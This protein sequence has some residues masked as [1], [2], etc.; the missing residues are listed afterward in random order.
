MD[1][2]YIEAVQRVLAPPPTS[3]SRKDLD[4]EAHFPRR[5]AL[6]EALSPWLNP[7]ERVVTRNI[8]PV[9]THTHTASETFDTPSSA[10]RIVVHIAG[11]NGKGSVCELLRCSSLAAGHV[12]GTFT[13][14]HLHTIRERMRVGSELI[15]KEDFARIAN[16][17]LPIFEA[18]QWMVFFDKL[19][20]VALVWFGEKRINFLVLETG[21]GGRFDPTNFVNNPKLCVLTGIGLDHEDMLGSTVAAIAWQKAGIIK[22]GCGALVTHCNQH[23]DALAVILEAAAAAGVPVN[24]AG[25]YESNS[26]KGL[27]QPVPEDDSD[28]VSSSTTVACCEE[29]CRSACVPS[30]AIQENLDIARA[31]VKVLGLPEDWKNSMWP[32]RFEEFWAPVGDRRTRVVVDGAH[33]VCGLQ[34]LKDRLAARYPLASVILVFGAAVDK[35][36]SGMVTLACKIAVN[37]IFVAARGPRATPPRALA[38]HLLADWGRAPGTDVTYRP[39]LGPVSEEPENGR[40]E[41]ESSAERSTE[42]SAESSCVEPKK[43][44]EESETVSVSRGLD[45]A[46]KLA[47]LQQEES[48]VVVC[49]SLFVAAEAREALA[50][51]W[52]FLFSDED[53]VHCAQDDRGA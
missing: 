23:A 44:L 40:T 13:S 49:G 28:S 31:C 19:L 3:L 24:L 16:S 45:A 22:K 12:V 33:N 46:V 47:S 27:L 25:D 29:S 32:A 35:D 34:S 48:M 37:I 11:T 15:T 30:W 17:L 7:K 6:F 50:A 41:E 20:A 18:N 51:R 26:D 4:A 52:S 9:H 39:L 14:P 43:V 36:T 1:I 8:D 21:I 2:T 5:V 10:T 38:Q 53:T 42:G